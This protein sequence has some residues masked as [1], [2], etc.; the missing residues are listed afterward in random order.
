MG[1]RTWRLPDVSG[2]LTS[3]EGLGSETGQFLR[4]TEIRSNQPCRAVNISLL[5]HYTERNL[6]TAGPFRVLT[7]P[8]SVHFCL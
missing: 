8:P 5:S 1:G 4:E 7:L 3:S 6:K 2:N